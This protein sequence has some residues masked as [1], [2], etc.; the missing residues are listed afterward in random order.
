MEE[1]KE[2]KT[3]KIE[4]VVLRIIIV[5]LF[6]FILI[7][8]LI[9]LASTVMHK[10]NLSFGKYKIY[11]MK[12]ENQKEIAQKGDL[13]IAKEY[14]L[15]EI[16]SGDY[17]VY[18]KNENYHSN[19]VLSTEM[20]NQIMNIETIN[21]ESFQYEKEIEGKVVKIIPKIGNVIYFI[22]TIPGRI[23]YCILTIMLFITLRILFTKN[24]KV[25]EQLEADDINKTEEINKEDRINQA[26]EANKSR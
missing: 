14:N 17:I 1:K 2:Q 15:K 22:R 12:T 4:K 26:N 3:K 11:I 5:L 23:I 7:T 8:S 25:K 13:V 9:T 18:Y 20:K 21:G 10:E 19:K 6:L 24:K 16:K